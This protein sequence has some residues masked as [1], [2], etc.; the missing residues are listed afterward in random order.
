MKILNISLDKDI[1]NRNS[2]VAKRIIEYGNLVDKYTVVALAYRDDIITLSDKVRVITVNKTGKI[3]SLLKMKDRVKNTLKKDNYD[4]I[5]VQ[6]IYFLGYV[7]VKIAQKFKIGLEV[8]VHGFEKFY[9][10]RKLLAHYVFKNAQSIRVVSQRL[11]KQLIEDFNILEDKIIVIPIFLKVYDFIKKPHSV[12]DKFTFLTIG[13]L[14]PVKNIKMQIRALAEIVKQ[15]QKVELWI[16]G[17]GPLRNSLEK[18]VQSLRLGPYVQFWGWQDQADEFY[19]KADAFLLTSYSE[20]WPLVI[21]E[22]INYNIPIIMTDVG[23]AGELIIN[24]KSGIV[25]PLQDQKSLEKAMLELIDN[26]DLRRKFIANA[27]K[28][29]LNLPNKQENLA[30]YRK[31]W[32]KAKK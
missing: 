29:L 22:A 16:I 15:D 1:I 12:N 13:R 24:N 8:Q 18:L 25:I 7:A 3:W 19:T 28:A 6:D 31:S 17:D 30:L 14:V 32:E 9:G 5:T 26:Q 2:A 27:E 10:L 21:M 23:S 4:L 11:K 20:G